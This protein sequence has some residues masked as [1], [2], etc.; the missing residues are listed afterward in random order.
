MKN[1]NDVSLYYEQLNSQKDLKKKHHQIQT[2]YLKAW[3]N[4][5]DKLFY[6]TET[7]KIA[8]NNA[9]SLGMVIDGYKANPINQEDYKYISSIINNIQPND[10]MRKLCVIFEFVYHSRNNEKLNSNAIENEYCQIE[11]AMNPLIKI[12]KANFIDYEI[13][14][15][16]K[17]S[18]VRYV[19]HQF[20][21]TDHAKK[22]FLDKWCK[23]DIEKEIYQRHYWFLGILLG[24]N[25]LTNIKSSHIV[26]MNNNTDE[27]FITSTNPVMIRNGYNRFFMPLSPKQAIT[28]IFDDSS[29]NSQ[30]VDELSKEIVDYCNKEIY[31]NSKSYG[32]CLVSKEE[33]DLKLF[34]NLV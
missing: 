29:Y 27:N 31:E 33:N 5:N 21:R 34:Q 15:K 23:N 24:E 2:Y 12:A 8:Q 10:N 14:L 7:G 17:E 30:K 1:F 20:Y 22:V 18:I 11:E 25:Y 26:I 28:I 4:S 3:C 16:F 6:I 13:I 32:G 19:V 9:K